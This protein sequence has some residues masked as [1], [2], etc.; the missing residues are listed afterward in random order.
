[1]NERGSKHT[2]SVVIGA[3]NAADWI[4]QTLDSVLA[5]THPIHEVLVVDD[6]S[7]DATREIVQSY[8]GV[9]QYMAEEHRGRPHRNRGI[10]TSSGEYVAFVDADDY[11]YPTKIEAEI[12]LLRARQVV[13]CTCESQWLDSASGQLIDSVNA[14]M[15]EGDILEALLLNNFLVAST[16]LVARHVFDEVGLFDESLAVAPVEDWD[17]WLRIAAR[18]PV[19]CVRERLAVLRLHQDSFLAATPISR[20]VRSLEEVVARAVDREP[21]RLRKLRRQALFNIYH[22]AGVQ[23]FRLGWSRE[24]RPF[25]RRAFLN[26]PARPETIGYLMLTFCS[27]SV[28]ARLVSL[29][30]GLT[31]GRRTQGPEL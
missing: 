25:F 31:R 28:A 27:Q 12:R 11:W 9:V 17:M 10:R 8:G 3:Y 5:Q 22:A 13:W 23:Q 24:A 1:L 20:K 7:T 30:K 21:H 29:K 4:R 26:R 16:P 19:A 14:P 18:F 15:Q 6:G 2:V